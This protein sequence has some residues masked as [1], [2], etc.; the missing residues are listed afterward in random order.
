[1]PTEHP[2]P[3]KASMWFH[4]QMECINL[5]HIGVHLKRLRSVANIAPGL[6]HVKRDKG[7]G[8]RP[9]QA[10]WCSIGAGR[11][12]CRRE[13][14]VEAVV[15]AIVAL[16][17]AAVVLKVVHIVHEGGE[18]GH[19]FVRS[20]EGQDRA[21]AGTGGPAQLICPASEVVEGAVIRDDD[22]D[23]AVHEATVDEGRAGPSLVKRDKVST[24]KA[25]RH[26]N[27]LADVDI[28]GSNGFSSLPEAILI[29]SNNGVGVGVAVKKR[30]A[31]YVGV[32]EQ[33]LGEN[34]DSILCGFM[35]VRRSSV[36]RKTE[37][38]QGCGCQH[39]R[40]AQP[41]I[42]CTQYTGQVYL[43][44]IVQSNPRLLA[45]IC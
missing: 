3:P 21:D 10:D 34:T 28:C 7:G 9:R 35:S 5:E 33:N 31:Y 40:F 27:W 11:N 25:F 44:W 17:E 16:V 43:L 2:P 41:M 6:G 26:S 15:R 18:G 29:S 30:M 36:I 32:T 45:M 23:L 14:N 22:V 24:V 1:M 13:G 39:D 12:R 37:A 8:N 4:L 38:D 20:T 19:A 42:G